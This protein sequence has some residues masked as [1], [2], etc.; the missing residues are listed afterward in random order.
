MSTIQIEGLRPLK[1]EIRIQGSKNAVLPMMAAAVLH[2]GTTVLENVPRI[3][4]VFCMIDI[5][6][7]MGCKCEFHGHCLTIEADTISRIAIPRT[8]VTAMRSSIILLGAFLGRCGEAATYYPGGCSIGSR[9]IDLHLYGL[10]K[11]GAD[12]KECG[13]GKIVASGRKLY[14]NEIRFP[15]PSVG[16]TENV[17]LA[18]VLAS[19]TTVIFGAAREPEIVQLCHM[20]NGM[21]AKI[22][23]IGE[24]IITVEGVSELHDSRFQV[25]GDR[26]VAGTY[27]SCM[28]AASGKA[29]LAGVDHR[30]LPGVL[31]VLRHMGA[32]IETEEQGIRMTMR[33]R[34]SPVSLR[35]EPYPGF[36]TDLQSPMLSILSIS[37]G[38]GEVQETVFEG[39]FATAGE[40]RKM[41]AQIVVDGKR[42][43][44]T[45][46][47][48]LTGADVD[49]PDLRGG[50]ALV[51][52]GLAARGC[53]S[54]CGCEH[55]L[56]GYEDICRDLR[57]VGA[58]VRYVG[59]DS[60]AGNDSQ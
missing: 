22:N 10:R 25:N 6:N 20:L 53:T 58:Q 35:T 5:L 11:M 40:L 21:G 44:V 32:D 2:K 16:A 55:I 47:Y 26:I 8:Y 9:P 50:A 41:G 27:L 56:R 45:G 60:T 30:E 48:P 7:S 13:D 19:G 54:I 52:A 38:R 43:V 12:V 51:V 3:R 37:Q 29:V 4:D 24:D 59:K 23:G 46:R 33:R 49:A 15:F 34:P 57:A 28:M 14:G 42:A 17:L 36:P 1:G 18:A 31:D 39:R